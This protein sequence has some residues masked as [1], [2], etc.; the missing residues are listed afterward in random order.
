MYS[1]PRCNYT[2]N[3]KFN[4]KKHLSLI[5]PCHDSLQS[6]I[7]SHSLLLELS[8][9]KIK[10]HIC[11]YCSKTFSFQQSK[12]KHEKHCPQKPTRVNARST[13]LSFTL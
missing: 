12:H 11:K 7:S 5:N 3:I 1:C 8:P 13:V 6:N 4:F 2:T 9:S 10:T